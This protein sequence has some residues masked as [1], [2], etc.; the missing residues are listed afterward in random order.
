MTDKLQKK[1]RAAE[2]EHAE[3]ALTAH[4][5]GFEQQ[6][7]DDALML[8]GGINVTDKISQALSAESIRALMKFQEEKLYEHFGFDNFVAF[9]DNS[10]HAPMTKSQFYERKSILEKEGDKTFNLLN[11]L[12]MS[13]SKRKLLGKGNIK[14]EDDTVFITDEDGVET[15]IEMT[16]RSRLLE[17][18][19][20]L[21]DANADKSR[22]LDKAGKRIDKLEE[23]VETLKTRPADIAQK[24]TH[25]GAFLEAVISL[26]KLTEHVKKELTA[27]EK[28]QHSELYLNS[29]WVAFNHLKIAYGRK[30]LHYN[31]G[32][33][34]VETEFSEIT[35][36]LNDQELSALI[37]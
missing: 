35:S 23:S 6:Q 7:R 17:T 21:A 15:S 2:D 3:E 36:E 31:D 27:A 18:L 32:E 11:S 1:I 33:P 5:T 13:V 9:L 14:V 12:S 8:L 20:A 24:D 19:S 28:K 37:N 10:P 30:D 25:Y 34:V 22:K 4:L 29:L 16:D 26:N